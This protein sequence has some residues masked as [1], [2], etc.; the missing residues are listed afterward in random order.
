MSIGGWV[1]G[2]SYED[3]LLGV[4]IQCNENLANVFYRLNL[5]EAFGTGIPKIMRGYKETY[6]KPE[7]IV[8][9][10]VFK[11]VLPNTNSKQNV[12]SKESSH[13]EKIMRFL[14]DKEFVTR[15]EVENLLSV[16][17]ASVARILRELVDDD[18]L[19]KVGSGRKL[20]YEKQRLV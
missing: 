20:R 19:I 2:I 1:R 13:E 5:I 7:V 17:Q 14:N 12:V 6:C 10:N 4:S 11:V 8:T 16:S 3:M 18:K 9:Y 15:K